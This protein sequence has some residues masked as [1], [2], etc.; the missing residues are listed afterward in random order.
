M[1]NE[2][3]SSSQSDRVWKFFS[4]VKLTIVLLLSLAAT[5]II[6]TLIPQNESPEEY[7]RAFGAVFY[8][9]FDALDI[10]DMYHSW[11][12]QVLLL[13]LTINVVVCSI[14]RLP[15]IW[16]VVRIKRPKLNPE[17][18]KNLPDRHEFT[19][20]ASPDQ[21]KASFAAVAEK[22]YGYHTVEDANEGFAVYGEKGRWTRLGVYTVHCSV[23]LLLFG[24]LI[25]SLFGFEGFVNLP[26][27][28]AANSIRL[29]KSGLIQPLAFE[30]RC[31]D[32]NISF[33]DSHRGMPKEFRSTLTLLEKGKPVLTRDII[34][35]DPLRYKGINIYQASYGEMPS[36]PPRIAIDTEKID[37][38]IV[39]RATGMVYQQTAAIGD[40]LE[41]SEEM[42]TF[43]IKE[44]IE[45]AEFRGQPI[46]QAFIGILT[47]NDGEPR[48]LLL[49]LRF[50]KF[51]RMRKG[52][53]TISVTIPQDAH[54]H[55]AADHEARYF[56]GLQVTKDPG[57]WIV[58]AGFMI[59][60]V[61]CFITFFMSH[62]RV[63][64]LVEK[65]GKKTR[66]M[67]SGMANKN[68]IGMQKRIAL[69]SQKLERIAAM[70][71]DSA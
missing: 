45:E 28:E 5:S 36:P 63:Y 37:L 20:D 47:P 10:F 26:E 7:F 18:L 11:W 14:D 61:G 60:I 40:E 32:F 35:N 8:R 17:R 16:K 56:T 3:G 52:E 30:I 31:D 38:N 34:V 22:S 23:I 49:P 57:V 6:G 65:T 2:A 1:E 53:Q 64:I 62:Q 46:G 58:Y 50:P 9:I 69:L 12:F 71:R 27:G 44:Y 24:G 41:L 54:S 51:D 59:M 43:V 21:L 4:S 42:G 55:T 19:S 66:I 29:R 67:V 33:Y 48:E 25:G 70:N 13:M 68:K 39:S 15:G